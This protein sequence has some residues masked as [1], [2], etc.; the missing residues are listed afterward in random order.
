MYIYSCV[1]FVVNKK[2]VITGVLMAAVFVMIAFVPATDNMHTAQNNTATNNI[3]PQ[4]EMN[5][6]TINNINSRF[7]QNNFENRNLNW[8]PVNLSKASLLNR[9]SIK[10]ST[11]KYAVINNQIYLQLTINNSKMPQGAGNQNTTLVGA[12]YIEYIETTDNS[13][14]IKSIIYRENVNKN[15][16][17]NSVY[18]INGKNVKLMSVDPHTYHKS[19]K[20]GNAWV[21]Y[22]SD[23]FHGPIGT[24][25]FTGMMTLIGAVA[26]L[27]AGAVA[28]ATVAIAAVAGILGA[29]VAFSWATFV[30][31]HTTSQNTTVPYVEID[32]SEG[33]WWDFWDT[34]AYGELGAHSNQA[35]NFNGKLVY[36]G[37]WLYW[38]F[39][40][41]EPPDTGLQITSLAQHASVW[42]SVSPPW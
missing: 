42:P 23:T 22:A 27:A 2:R 16:G 26:G 39:L 8:K 5:A 38:P 14:N 30:N 11:E 12:N 24:G 41:S 37:G 25:D 33:Y 18:I 17:N 13:L 35:Y 36:S 34:G 9:S 40:T 3:L 20:W 19:Y 4:F 21:F 31:L 29:V 32:V 6:S 7:A 15:I 28:D 10:N 1:N